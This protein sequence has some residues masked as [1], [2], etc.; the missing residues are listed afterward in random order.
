MTPKCFLCFDFICCFL[1]LHRWH[2]RKITYFVIPTIFFFLHRI[3]LG[4]PEWERKAHLACLLRQSKHRIG[5]ILP[6]G[7][8]SCKIIPW[9]PSPLNFTA[10]GWI[11]L[12][13]YGLFLRCLY[14]SA[15]LDDVSLRLREKRGYS[16]GLWDIYWIITSSI[17][18]HVT[19]FRSDQKLMTCKV[20]SRLVRYKVWSV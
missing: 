14:I 16:R 10:A 20:N 6:R 13:K 1:Q 11:I 18:G 7:S 2:C 5:L 8:A 12:E 3:K 15:W 19:S 17:S 4:N 9:L